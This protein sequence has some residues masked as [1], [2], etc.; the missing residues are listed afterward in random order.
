LLPGQSYLQ[1]PPNAVLAQQTD[2][3]YGCVVAH[4]PNW[5][6]IPG[7]A[8]D[9]TCWYSYG[10]KEYT[11]ANY[12]WVILPGGSSLQKA[13]GHDIPPKAVSS[14][15]QKDGAA[16]LYS[17]IAITSYGQIAGKAKAGTCWYPYGSL[18]YTT[19]NFMW[20]CYN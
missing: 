10:G 4:T 1:P 19:S 17:A 6:D 15:H 9:G 14:G 2:G 8:K 18:E 3:V 12:S 11:T 20:V 7:K 13:Q 16:T 5:G